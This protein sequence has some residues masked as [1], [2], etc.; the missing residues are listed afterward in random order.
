MELLVGMYGE[1]IA[2]LTLALA[3]SPFFKKAEFEM[4]G[5]FSDSNPYCFETVNSAIWK[6][7]HSLRSFG[8]KLFVSRSVI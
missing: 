8:W 2:T 7:H 4:W 6:P 5:S 1:L 3:A